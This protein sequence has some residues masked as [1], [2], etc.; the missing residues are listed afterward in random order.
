[1]SEDEIDELFNTLNKIRAET[2]ENN[3]MLKQIIKVIN[4]Y[5]SNSNNDD[6]KDFSMNVIA[7]ILSDKINR[8]R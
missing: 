1:M 4:Y 7:N 6:V 2:H 8:R 3:I 5:I